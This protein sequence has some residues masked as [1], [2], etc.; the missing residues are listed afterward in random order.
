[1][2]VHLHVAPPSFYS[3]PD[4]T[5]NYLKQLTPNVHPFCPPP[6]P[7]PRRCLNLTPQTFVQPSLIP[8]AVFSLQGLRPIQ[9]FPPAPSLI[10]LTPRTPDAVRAPPPA[11]LATAMTSTTDFDNAEITQQY[12]HINTRFD[13]SDEE[14]DNDNSSAR[15]FERSRIKALAGEHHQGAL[16]VHPDKVC[17]Q[18]SSLGGGAFRGPWSYLVGQKAQL[19]SGPC[20]TETPA[21]EGRWDD[22]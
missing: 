2:P 4:L 5:V 22:L 10:P 14:L 20:G 15:L 7:Q 13:L 12:S 11:T 8:S 1:M 18:D 21:L 17:S 3:C 9:P 6:L 16:V 19:G